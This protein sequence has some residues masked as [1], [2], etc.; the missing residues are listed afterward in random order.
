MKKYNLTEWARD[1]K[2][3]DGK[4]MHCGS[5]MDL[6]A[7]HIK[8]KSTHPDLLLNLDNGI[9]L[10]YRCHKAEH[11]RNRPIR[12]RSYTPQRK[13]LIKKIISL[14]NQLKITKEL[15]SQMTE[16]CNYIHEELANREQ[17]INILLHKK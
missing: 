8:Q 3:R 10:C 13:T 15:L 6:H 9:T 17:K 7:H 2:N 5:I 12:I 16:E 4:C 11:E 1:I 14:E